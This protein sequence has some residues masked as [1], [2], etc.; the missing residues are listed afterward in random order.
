M[1]QDAT[2]NELMAAA[3]WMRDDPGPFIDTNGAAAILGVQCNTSAGSRPYQLT[4]NGPDPAPGSFVSLEPCCSTSGSAADAQRSR[5]RSRGVTVAR[6][7]RRQTRMVA[8]KGNANRNGC[9][10][11]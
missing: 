2:F 9:T 4:D 6:A 8:P 3:A 11:G 5:T 1:D 7:T 10:A